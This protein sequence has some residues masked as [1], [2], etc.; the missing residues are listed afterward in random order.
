MMKG[1]HETDSR[2]IY[3]AADIV[4][5]FTRAGEM[6]IDELLAVNAELKEDL[7]SLGQRLCRGSP[8]WRIPGKC[9]AASATLSEQ[10]EFAFI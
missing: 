4:C 8:E 7:S 9:L 6:K 1:Y 2:P 3:V 10:I 5:P